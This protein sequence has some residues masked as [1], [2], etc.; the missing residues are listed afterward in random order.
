MLFKILDHD[1]TTR[2]GSGSWHL[3]KGK[4][5]GRWMAPIKGELVPCENGYHLCRETDL[6]EWLGPAI[7]EVEYRVPKAPPIGTL[8]DGYRFIGG[9]PASKDSWEKVA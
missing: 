7:F 1:G 6:L 4:R 9:D 3:P 2:Q 8:E 5:P